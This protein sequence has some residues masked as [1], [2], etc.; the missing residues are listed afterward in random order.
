MQLK[1]WNF[2]SQKYEYQYALIFYF[3]EGFI[4]KEL[5]T[6]SQFQGQQLYK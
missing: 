6:M 3:R 2:I 4:Q 1:Y 5:T